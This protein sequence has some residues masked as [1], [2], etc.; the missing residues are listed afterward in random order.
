MKTKAG[1]WLSTVALV[2]NGRIFCSG[3]AIHPRLVVTAGHCI[4]G[5]TNPARIGVYV[6]EGS[7]GGRLTAQYTAVKMAYSPK[8]SNNEDGWNDIGYLVLDKP[9]DLPVSAYIPVLMDADETAEVLQSGLSAYIVGFG[10]R[11]DGYGV[12][13]EVDATITKVG[14]SEVA[15][16]N[17]GKDS[18]KGDSGGPAFA[19][20]SNGEWRVFGVVSRGGACGKGG[21]YGRMNANICWIQ[22]DSGVDLGLTSY[23]ATSI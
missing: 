1:E 6:G 23:C 13:Y 15:L 18:C 12:K 3:T 14:D 7:E 10:Y 9:L 2:T 8:Y 5:S 16:G 20:L 22:E 11:M 19:R 4:Q 17:D 21:I